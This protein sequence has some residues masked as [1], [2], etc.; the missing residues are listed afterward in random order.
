M[1]EKSTRIPALKEPKRVLY[2]IFDITSNQIICL[3][4]DKGGTTENT[5][6]PAGDEGIFFAAG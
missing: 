3:K 1:D 5:F 4:T 2:L 6:V